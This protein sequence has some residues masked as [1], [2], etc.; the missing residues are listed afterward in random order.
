MA[1]NRTPSGSKL[2]RRLSGHLPDV[3]HR[4]G[5]DGGTSSGA[6]PPGAPPA[7]S[8]LDGRPSMRSPSGR[9]QRKEERRLRRNSSS[10]KR[11]KYG[12]P[13]PEGSDTEDEASFR[14]DWHMSRADEVKKMGE[15]LDALKKA[16]QL[17]LD[18][19]WAMYRRFLRARQHDIPR[20]VE[21]WTNH[22]AWRREI[23]ADTILEDFHFPERDAFISL[24]P[25]GYCNVD[26]IGRPVYIQQLGQLQFKKLQELTTDER[27]IKFHVQEY[28]RCVRYILPA[29][30]RAAGRNIEQT[31]AILD[32]KGVGLRHLTGAV[33]KMLQQVI[34]VDQNNYPEMLGKTAIIN[35]GAVIG[36]VFPLV[37]P[38]LD[39]RTQNK[40][41]VCPRDFKATLL[42]HIA[43]ENLPEYL[44]G[45]SKATLLDDAGP[46]NDQAI[47]DQIDA[48]LRRPGPR[49]KWPSEALHQ[50]PPSVA[51]SLAGDSPRGGSSVPPSAQPSPPQ[52]PFQPAANGGRNAEGFGAVGP[53]PQTPAAPQRADSGD[54]I[55]SALSADEGYASAADGYATA[56]DGYASATESLASMSSLGSQTGSSRLPLPPPRSMAGRIVAAAAADSD[57]EDE[58]QS[59]TPLIPSKRQHPASPRV[60]TGANGST[61][62]PPAVATTGGD[63][64]EDVLP[65]GASPTT[66]PRPI[67]PLLSPRT[68]ATTTQQSIAARVQALEERVERARAG[69]GAAVP[70]A[71]PALAPGG[72]LVA[73][74]EALE[75]ALDVLLAA[76]QA[77][78]EEADAKQN[79]GCCGGGCTIM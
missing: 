53:A 30:S 49:L 2:L 15:F 41:E 17:R 23:G 60:R 48:E 78:S 7:I 76:Q 67:R 39:K 10:G 79:S 68:P 69:L 65:G 52:S 70:V 77:A 73:R 75:A 16:D 44:G 42:Q 38:F 66:P 24:Y 28:E 26:K 14:A 58:A 55:G 36:F 72:P 54:S 1:A 11:S 18:F 13:F 33:K 22:L 25:Q 4:G 56:S 32:A 37:R 63:A 34:Q 71:A 45:K 74:V 51:S 62:A 3:L 61:A 21:M 35:G 29:C 27:M 57:S 47:V 40:I 46:W 19:D 9:Q 43:A 20:A 59:K 31:F 50:A 8:A 64:G 6:A 5:E 12:S